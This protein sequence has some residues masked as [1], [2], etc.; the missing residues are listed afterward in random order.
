LEP[1][2]EKQYWRWPE[3]RRTIPNVKATVDDV[4]VVGVDVGSVSSKSVIMVNATPYAYSIIR[5]VT[6]SERS[7]EKAMSWAM[8]DTSVNRDDIKYIV[9][10]GYGRVN[11]DFADKA[12]TEIS[13]HAKGANWIW[14]R[15]VRTIMDMGGQDCKAIRC[16][17]SG[18]VTSFVM[19]D[20]CAAGT[21]RG[22]EVFA[23]LLQIPIEE[24]GTLSLN[25]QDEPAALN[26][27]CVVFQKTEAIGL[28]QQG[29]SK[30]NILAALCSQNAHKAVQLLR[31][32]GV[33]K[34][35]VVTGGI[36]KNAGVVQRLERELGTRAVP[37][38]TEFDPQLAGALG[39]AL[40]AADAARKRAS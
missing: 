23:D 40:F 13:C 19:N 15:S 34:E 1:T 6:G 35:L 29:M 26:S 7:A 39:A 36:G 4:I 10:T 18:R 9:A 17:Q 14:G 37:A 21:G 20:K 3:Y 27:T 25:V 30:E 8:E 2:L 32:V 5:T 31:R 24:I 38:N 16:D 11:V 28:L 12:V 22:I 33:E